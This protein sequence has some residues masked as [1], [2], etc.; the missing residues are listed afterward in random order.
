MSRHRQ[1]LADQLDFVE[2]VSD[3]ADLLPLWQEMFE[4]APPA[5]ISL[6]MMKLAVGY[7]L[8]QRAYGG[9]KPAIV[10]HLY[11]VVDEEARAAKPPED[12]VPPG[13]HLLRQWHGTIYEAV[14]ETDG[15]LVN[16][17]RHSS[18]SDAAMAITGTRWSGPRFFGLRK[19]KPK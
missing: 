14:V 15:V 5:Y 13:T 17:Q 19:V 12:R 3:R 6:K 1:K 7:K 18:L 10:R 2:A 8:Q 11:A 9:L 4:L 16:G